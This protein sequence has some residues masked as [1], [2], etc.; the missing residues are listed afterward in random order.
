MTMDTLLD[1]VVIIQFS[2]NIATS[3]KY[4]NGQ[5]PKWEQSLGTWG[6]A[7]VIHLKTNFTP[8]LENFGLFCQIVVY[9]EVHNDGVY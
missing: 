6:E 3:F 2:D 9:A 8:K 1:G 7:G 5:L 4:W